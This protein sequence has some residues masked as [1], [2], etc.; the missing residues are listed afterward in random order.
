MRGY[1]KSI[2]DFR[3]AVNAEIA[4]HIEGIVLE[5]SV[6]LFSS[7]SDSP[8]L[9]CTYHDLKDPTHKDCVFCHKQQENNCT[10]R[11]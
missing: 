4:Q 10:W 8:Y 3:V 6:D 7:C 9:L 11:K 5:Y 1:P 2:E